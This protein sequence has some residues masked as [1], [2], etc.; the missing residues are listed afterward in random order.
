MRASVIILMYLDAVKSL[1]CLMLMPYF[2]AKSEINNTYRSL[3]F[4]QL[5]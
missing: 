5:L 1:L 4:S 2:I 3:L